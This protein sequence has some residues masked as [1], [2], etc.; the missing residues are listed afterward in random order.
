MQKSS[1]SAGDS[2]LDAAR[3]IE[4]VILEAGDEADRER[5]LPARVVDAML[6]A[7]LFQAPAPRDVGGADLDPLTQLELYE[8][9]TSID[10]ATGWNLMI[11]ALSTALVSARVGD[12]AIDALYAG[13]DWP[14]VAGHIVPRG[15]LERAAGD[16][17]HLTGRWSFAS[18]IHQASW[19]LSACALAEDD[20]EVSASPDRPAVRVAVTP[21]SEVVIHDNWHVAGLRGTGSCDYSIDGALVKPGFTFDPA[22]EALRGSP[23]NR[24]P[25]P[26]I[27]TVGHIAFALG[28]CK[29]VIAELA[30]GYGSVQRVRARSSISERESVQRE[31]GR[32][33]AMYDGAR[34]LAFDAVRDSWETASQ[35]ET[36]T[37]AQIQREMSA[38]YATDVAVEIASFAY[39]AAGA[40]ALFDDSPLQRYLR[41]ILAA[42]Q[43]ATVSDANY[44]SA[45]RRRFE[46]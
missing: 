28:V 44:V 12:D 45:G 2:V 24:T 15:S 9:V 34:L 20:P 5:R 27:G 39:R 16:G 43:H 25:I 22:G 33:I 32:A 30:G 11:G 26:A 18:G 36:P 13:D 7:G 31:I 42:Q 1:T 23:W 8:L 6:D 29:R 40:Q 19:V 38:T 10:T 21:R 41:D 3:E 35:G 17:F 46:A 4:A 14:I 37:S